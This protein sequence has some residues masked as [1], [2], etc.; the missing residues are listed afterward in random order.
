MRI[1][2]QLDWE[3][4]RFIGDP[5]GF[6]GRKVTASC[7]VSRD[8]TGQAGNSGGMTKTDLR[9]VARASDDDGSLDD[10]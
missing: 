2:P 1:L 9:I 3:R 6:P 4:S 10:P 7:Q 5:L 8:S